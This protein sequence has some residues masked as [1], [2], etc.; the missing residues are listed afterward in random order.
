MYHRRTRPSRSRE[1]E[2]FLPEFSNYAR[3][4]NTPA[5]Q[6]CARSMQ[7]IRVVF[8]CIP[9]SGKPIWATDSGSRLGRSFG[10]TLSSRTTF[11]QKLPY[12]EKIPQVL[13][14]FWLIPCPNL[15]S[16]KQLGGSLPRPC[17]PPW[18]VHL[19]CPHSQ[20]T[21]EL[22]CWC[23]E[24]IQWSIKILSLLIRSKSWEYCSD[25]NVDGL[26]V[27]HEKKTFE[28]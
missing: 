17:T 4:S 7:T 10:Q 12:L 6:N 14:E 27:T 23:M 8:F 5:S 20:T 2:K 21:V 24:N 25:R 1:A 22:R 13:P 28:L 15:S 11:S 26:L 18:F 9:N 3:I 16:P 19:W